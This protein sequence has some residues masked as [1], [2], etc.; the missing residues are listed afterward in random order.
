M[1]KLSLVM[2]IGASIWFFVAL[3]DLVNAYFYWQSIPDGIDR[4]S[5]SL[6]NNVYQLFDSL[7]L[8]GSAAM[9][10]LLYRIHHQLSGKQVNEHGTR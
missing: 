6:S 5:Y 8:F 10:E 1:N 7:F 2:V 4:A 9:V 3:F